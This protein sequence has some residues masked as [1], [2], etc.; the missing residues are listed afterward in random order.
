MFFNNNICCFINLA[1]QILWIFMETECPPYFYF[2]PNWP[3]D[4]E[5]ASHVPPL[6]I[7]VSTKFKVDTTIHCL[8]MASLLL[9]RYVSLWPWPLTFWPWSVD[10]PFPQI[11]IIGAKMIVWRIRGKIIRSV[12]CN[13]VYNSCA[14]CNAHIHMNRPNSSR[15]WVLYHWAHFTACRFIFVYVLF[16]VH[17]MHV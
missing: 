8:V 6:T 1:S 2:W 12:L 9:I 3:T 16:C 14:Q 13:I 17:C 4:L 5:S 10:T 15:D 7:K 11:D